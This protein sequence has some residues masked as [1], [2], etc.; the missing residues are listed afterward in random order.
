[1]HKATAGVALALVLLGLALW[2]GLGL[3]W[4]GA[5]VLQAQQA[6]QGYFEEQ[7]VMATTLYFLAFMGVTAL[8]LPGASLMMLVG[9]GCMGFGL[10]TVL[11]TLA[12]AV[13]ALLTMLATRH[14][15]RGAVE[16]RFHSPLQKLN[17]GL[18]KNAVVTMLS[19]RLAP[20]I[21]FVLFNMLAGMTRTK[22]WTFLWTSVLGMLPGT[23]LYV[24]A[25]HQISEVRS[26]QD[27]FSAE[28]MLSLSALALLPWLLHRLFKRPD[29]SEQTG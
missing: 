26:L 12:S 7:P 8:C 22:P 20:V 15:F 18:E 17:K 24:N 16:R 2:M 14:L 29:I 23:V 5:D 11:S 25:G 3:Q 10:C 21:P 28:V 19:L 4:E 27:V 9:A 13:G 1:M 6:L